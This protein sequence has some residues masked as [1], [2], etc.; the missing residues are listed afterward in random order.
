MGVWKVQSWRAST[1]SK[2]R[3]GWRNLTAPQ[4]D[5]SL[6]HGRDR[7]LSLIKMLTKFSTVRSHLPHRGMALCIFVF[8]RIPLTQN[9]LFFKLQEARKNK[10]IVTCWLVTS[11]LS[12]PFLYGNKFRFYFTAIMITYILEKVMESSSSRIC[13]M[14]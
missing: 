9:N 7:T 1:V 14:T 11:Y 6:L 10:Q 3:N 12:L 4:C 2:L 8:K 13:R 5:I